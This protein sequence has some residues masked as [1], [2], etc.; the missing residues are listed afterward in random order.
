VATKIPKTVDVASP[1]DLNLLALVA[2][3]DAIR[4]EVAPAM[5][6][7]MKAGVNVVMITGDN[8]LT[9]RAIAAEAG[10]YKKGDEVLTGGEIDKMSTAELEKKIGLVTVF[11]RVTPDHKLKIIEA[12]RRRGE[13]IAMTGDGVNDAPSL[14]AAD[15][16]VAMGKVGTEV[17]KEAAD[18]ILLDDNFGSIVSAIEEGRS[19][20]R[21]IKKVILYLFS[22][23]FGLVIA[24]SG[25]I[26]I[27]LPLPILPAQIIWLNFVTDGFLD[28]SLAMEPKDKDLLANNKSARVGLL[29]GQMVRR[30]IVMALPMALGSLYIFNRYLEQGE[31]KAWTASLTVLAVFQWFNAWNCRSDKQSIFTLNPFTNKYLIAS[32]FIVMALQLAAVYTAPLQNILHTTALELT[33]WLIIFA[34]ASTIIVTEEIRKLLAR[35][36]SRGKRDQASVPALGTSQT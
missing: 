8:G 3:K 9:A 20:Y 32:T 17:A 27:G 21:T 28:V 14:V 34:V 4:P 15:L 22:T 6:Q 5:A 18:I 29:D 10:I 26:L 36:M 7:A 35:W 13:I 31:T 30:M 33:D 19:I 16:G 23:S 11:A 25:A 2:M 12:Y 24:I 1:R